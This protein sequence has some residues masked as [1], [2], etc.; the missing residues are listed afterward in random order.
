MTKATT[1]WLALT[2]RRCTDSKRSAGFMNKVKANITYVQQ[3]QETVIEPRPEI[4]LGLY[5]NSCRKASSSGL[6]TC[7]K[8]F[9]ALAKQH[10]LVH[11]EL[12]H[13]LSAT[14]S[15]MEILG[16][17]EEIEPLVSFESVSAGIQ[18]VIKFPKIQRGFEGEPCGKLRPPA[19]TVVRLYALF[20]PDVATVTSSALASVTSTSELES[21]ADMVVTVLRRLWQCYSCD[22][23][24]TFAQ[25]SAEAIL[26]VSR[27]IDPR[28]TLQKVDVRV[29]GVRDKTT[30]KE[31]MYHAVVS[32]HE[33]SDQD[34]L[35]GHHLQDNL[36]KSS[37]ALSPTTEDQ[38][39]VQGQEDAAFGEENSA[40]EVLIQN[41]TPVLRDHL[42]RYERTCPDR[43]T[44]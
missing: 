37:I 26:R 39:K 5:D 6:A 29:M 2:W 41:R 20:D 18:V 31:H 3:S 43:T 30:D 23:H 27:F 25:A 35:H 34:S 44:Y 9:H 17:N 22:T 24:S 13:T 10:S 14:R 38:S 32:R 28:F 7:A 40:A 19:S 36:Q 11:S 16:W 33:G 1:L 21:L 12:E 4:L 8:A 15:L 42:R